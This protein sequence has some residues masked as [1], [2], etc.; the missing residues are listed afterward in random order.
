MAGR[1][2]RPGPGRDQHGVLKI[3]GLAGLEAAQ[4][5]EEQAETAGFPA[6]QGMLHNDPR[7]RS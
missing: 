3:L 5:R 6:C 4:M 2:R 1:V 7:G